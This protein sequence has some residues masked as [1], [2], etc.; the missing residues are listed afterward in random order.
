MS[1]VDANSEGLGVSESVEPEETA[2]KSTQ[3]STQKRKPR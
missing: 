2:V 1:A 3:K